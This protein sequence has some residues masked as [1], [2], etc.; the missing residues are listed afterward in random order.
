MTTNKLDENSQ[1]L[2]NFDE[3]VSHETPKSCFY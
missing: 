3:P 1:V 2:S